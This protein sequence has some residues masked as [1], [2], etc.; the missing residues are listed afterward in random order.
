LKIM[1]GGAP[2]TKAFADRIGADGFGTN[3]VAAAEEAK[4]LMR[5]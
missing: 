4:K 3:A 1:V 2:L 5:R